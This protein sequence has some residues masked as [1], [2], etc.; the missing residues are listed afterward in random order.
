MEKIRKVRKVKYVKRLTYHLFDVIKLEFEIKL[1][2]FLFFEHAGR[3]P[4]HTFLLD[5]GEFVALM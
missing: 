2:Q 3:P 4:T 1:L 5:P